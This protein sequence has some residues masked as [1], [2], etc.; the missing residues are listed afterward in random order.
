MLQS[1]H[2]RQNPLGNRVTVPTSLRK[3]HHELQSKLGCLLT[4]PRLHI[5]RFYRWYSTWSTIF[6][7]LFEISCYIS[8]EEKFFEADLSCDRSYS[9][10]EKHDFGSFGKI[11]TTKDLKNLFLSI[12]FFKLYLSDVNAHTWYKIWESLLLQQGTMAANF[13]P[14]LVL[15]M[16]IYH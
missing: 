1:K 6:C 10:P 3:S 2:L 5:D 4:I 11:V 8:L 15:E 13:D 14:Q 7:S 12:F 9:L 16:G